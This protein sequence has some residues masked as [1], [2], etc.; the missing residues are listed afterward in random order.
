MKRI[1]SGAG[2][3]ALCLTIAP[4]QAQTVIVANPVLNVTDTLM[5]QHAWQTY[6]KVAEQ[7]RQDYQ[8]LQL[9]L[10]NSQHFSVEEWIAIGDQATAVEKRV[11]QELQTVNGSAASGA[12]TVEQ[13]YLQQDIK[14]LNTIAAMA[15]NAQ[16][17]VQ[18]QEIT[19]QLLM[20]IASENL[21]QRQLKL[22]QAQDDMKR[23]GL[24]EQFNQQAQA[25]SL[26]P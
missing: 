18:L 4:C 24:W 25:D 2:V 6:L 22:A 10:R 9:Q 11:A 3:L 14:A 20:A 7:V 23:D 5:Q 15:P 16:G 21:K 17:S 12:A 19:N 13:G 1:L 8:M 26:N